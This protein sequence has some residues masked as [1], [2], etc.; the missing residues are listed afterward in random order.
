MRT[1]PAKRSKYGNTFSGGHLIGGEEVFAG[2]EFTSRNPSDLE[3]VVGVFPEAD[4]ATVRQAALAAREAFEAW[5][6]TPAPVRGAVLANLARILER[7]K[8]TLARLMTREVGKSLKEARGDVQEAI[9]TAIFF[10]S[11]GRRLYGQTVPSEM[12]N[13]ELYTF[14]RPLGV[15]GMITAGN[16]PIAVPSWKLIPAVLTGNTVVWKPSEDA[17]VLSYVFAKLFEEAGLPPGVI[18]VVFG[19]GKDSAGQYLVE[20]MDEGLLNK[21]A[22]TGSTAVGR[23]IGEVAGRNLIRA[24]LELGGKNPLVVMR[25]ADLDNAVEGAFF[26]A[27]A[28]GGQRCT[29]AGNIIVDAPIYEEFKRRF[30]ER[31]EATVVGNPV[32]Y[33]DVHYGP[34]FNERF[35]NRWL[36]HYDWAA[37]D[38]ATLLV[39]QRRITSDNPYPHFRGDPDAGWFGWPTVWEAR[40]GMRQTQ[41][42]IFGPTVNLIRV[43]G[44]D[45]AI[46]V[47]N[48]HP[49]GLSSAIYTNNRMWAYRFKTEIK[50]GMT[51]INNTTV[52]AEAHMPFGGVRASGNGGRESG[53]WVIEE[54]TYW[55]AVN[56]EFS[57]K[58]QLAQMDTEY[59]RPKEGVNWRE[60]LGL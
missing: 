29:S 8:E 54:Y 58:L 49:Y 17:P 56:D 41:E 18:N 30:L 34:F 60:V 39:G 38:G 28:T 52:G 15:V 9:D 57:G 26:S 25:D 51:N 59:T 22:F 50:A 19:F 2:P 4:K 44:I 7:E 16:F 46:Q 36:E 14:R 35:L 31:V 13:K 23:W 47:A 1:E 21:F 40:P 6:R 20:L 27:F 24:T 5:S 42:E 45:E 43:D 10:A 3:D 12:R 48:D 33:E 32:L 53:V 11:E 37:K 55:Q